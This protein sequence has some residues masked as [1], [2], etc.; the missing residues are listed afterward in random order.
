MGTPVSKT[1]DAVRCRSV[2][3][4]YNIFSNVSGCGQKCVLMML[5]KGHSCNRCSVVILLVWHGQCSD[6]PILNLVYINYDDLIGCAL[7]E[8]W[9]LKLGQLL[10]V[11]GK[12]LA[13]CS[14]GVVASI[15]HVVWLL[16]SSLL[17]GSL[18]SCLLVHAPILPF[19]RASAA[20][21]PDT[22][23]WEGIHCRQ[24]VWVLHSK[25][26]EENELL[27]SLSLWIS[28]ACRTDM[29]SDKNTTSLEVWGLLITCVAVICIASTSA[30]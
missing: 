3:L 9:I 10:I 8:A 13:C 18:C 12:H 26:R 7:F 25:S 4:P 5:W 15:D 17:L 27:S 1:N 2:R 28:M 24:T 19:A 11:D 30:L 22:S 16:W 14:G 21:F 23:Q 29:A 6:W 20:L